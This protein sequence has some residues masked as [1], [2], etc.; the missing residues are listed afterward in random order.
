MA[1][2]DV[3]AKAEARRMILESGV[4]EVIPVDFEDS[5]TAAATAAVAATADV[6]ED[7][8]AEAKV[9]VVESDVVEEESA[10]FA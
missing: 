6:V 1:V 2:G 8:V 7:V 5:S 9:D 10:P 4:E 3:A